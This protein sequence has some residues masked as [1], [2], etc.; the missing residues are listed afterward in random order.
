MSSLTKFVVEYR[1]YDLPFEFPVLVLTGEEWRISDVMSGRL[2]FHNCL[3][4]GIC[5]TDSGI[6]AFEG[7]CRMAYHAGDVTIIPRHVPHTTCSAK[8][9]KSL[10]SY[11]FVDI[12]SLLAG[13]QSA[14]GES[15][16]AAPDK[17]SHQYLYNRE[18]SPR[19]HFLANALMEEMSKRRNNWQEVFKSLLLVLYYEMCRSDIK[20][21]KQTGE[22]RRRSF[23]LTPVLEYIHENY[24]APMSMQELA[25]ICH[26]S[27]THFRRIFLSIMG[28]SPLNFIN[29]FRINQACVL[30]KTT[31]K[32]ILQI[33]E[34]VGIHSISN[35][36]RIFTATM[37][38]SPKEYRN[39]DFS[40]TL[41]PQRKY[42][43][44][45]K[46]WRLPE[47]RPEYAEEEQEHSNG[48]KQKRK[49]ASKKT[50]AS[51]AKDTQA[52]PKQSL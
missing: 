46:G 9:T 23:V 33:A 45:Y 2:H 38:V 15:G 1:I 42:V 49:R 4:I 21:P 13:L 37:R 6:L 12:N 27:E 51:D 41:I 3:E 44:P 18:Q 48:G 50:P 32:S 20:L 10:W 5:H 19:I 8:G 31:D 40:D 25:D 39:H 11:L 7:G 28:T 47:D 14:E 52:V 43:L 36:N 24:M 30:L 17:I 29:S 22:R 35:F 16:I 26:L 34:S